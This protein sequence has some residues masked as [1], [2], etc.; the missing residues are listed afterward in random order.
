MTSARRFWPTLAITAVLAA[1]GP[2]PAGPATPVAV[3][4]PSWDTDRTSS[5]DTVLELKA[6]QDRVKKVNAEVSPTVV[7][8]LI[9][10][11]A[12]SGVIVSEDGLVLTAAHVIGKPKRKLAVVL[13]DGSIVAGESLGVNKDADSGMVRITDKPPK[14][15]T[16]PG[17]KDGKWPFAPLAKSGDLRKGQWVVALGHPGGPKRDRLPPV[18]VGRFDNYNKSQHALRSDCTLVGGDSGGPLFDLDGNVVGIHS[19]IGLF[20]EYNIHV[21][22]EIFRSEWDDLLAGTVVDDLKGKPELGV[23]L[24]VKADT[25][26]VA[27][28]A[29]D[30]PAAKAGLKVGD[31]IVKFNGQRVGTADDLIDLVAD[32]RPT[33]RVEIE[34]RRGDETLTLKATLRKQD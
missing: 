8:I 18:R 24:D 14:S 22:T 21:P 6:L 27:D 7:G 13:P 26:K 10:S 17:A 3:A 5:P 29:D 32:S 4:L 34:V 25:A 11:G 31:V 9:G 20:L 30:S 23:T 19:R 28:V 1:A 16:W 2:A 12:G 33:D 15:A